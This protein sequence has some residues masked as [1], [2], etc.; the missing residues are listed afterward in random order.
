MIFRFGDFQLDSTEKTLLRDGHSVPVTPKVFDLLLFLTMRPGML[1]TKEELLAGIW[2]STAVEESNLSVHI[3][4]LRRLLGDSAVEPV[5]IE[6]VA[7]R[8]YRFI[9]AVRAASMETPPIREAAADLESAHPASKPPAFPRTKGGFALLAAAAMVGMA[10][11]FWSS[12]TRREDGWNPIPLTT[13]PGVEACPALSPDASTL[14][15]SVLS[16]RSETGLWMQ[17][18]DTRTPRTTKPTRLTD[19]Y[20]YNATWSPNGKEFA[21]LRVEKRNPGIGGD[22]FVLRA[23]K[24]LDNVDRVIR[25]MD[26]D[27]PAP[28]PMLHYAPDGE[29][30]LTS[31]GNGL[32]SGVASL[33]LVAIS[34]RTGELRNILDPVPGIVGDF[35]PVLSRDGNRL[36]FC[37]CNTTNACNLYVVPMR[38]LTPAGLPQRLTDSAT[39][40]FRPVFLQ[41]GSLLYP[42]GPPDSRTFWRTS[43]DLFGKPHSSSVSPM[44]EDVSQPTVAYTSEGKVRLI[45]VRNMIDPN[46][47]E[48]KLNRPD[49]SVV[50]ANS[51]IASTR[52]DQALAF[53]PDGMRIAFSSTRSGQW[54]IWSCGN[55]GNDCMQL[56]HMGPAYSQYPV[57][58]PNGEWI[59]FDSRPTSNANLF[60]VP[61]AG[62]PVVQLTS[63]NQLERRPVLVT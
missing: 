22:H 58:S 15:Y 55:E 34:T 57:W 31:E 36:A 40:E 26:F 18:L 2:P 32:P 19:Q 20:D 7:K 6:T 38:Q 50:A 42:L 56:T 41:D 14:L 48:L 10:A 13:A 59:A 35:A 54:E 63:G 39:P 30:I 24:V 60:M 62:G 21:Y 5:Y 33:H 37:R 51:V 12:S 16:P 52:S 17:K 44:G 4:A 27:G 29:W 8:G 28:G 46:I 25:V 53:S 49:G 61:S 43:F 11:I 1:V 47:W 45:Y 9:A 3:S 23:R